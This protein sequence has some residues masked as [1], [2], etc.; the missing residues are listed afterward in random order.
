MKKIWTKE[1]DEQLA[2]YLEK[3]GK[4]WALISTKM[5][6]RSPSQIASRWEKCI[7]PRLKKGSFT[8]EED[9]IIKKFVE[10]NGPQK[11]PQINKFLPNR[12]PKQCRER[13]FNHLDPNVTRG[14]W[15][16]E[17]DHIILYQHSILGPKWAL[18]AKFLPGRTDNAMI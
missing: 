5:D 15:S 18:I 8:P 4:Q 10:E 11:W 12:S 7:D 17:E 3:Y 1:E 6:G 13:W 14:N 16:M 2:Y 9:E